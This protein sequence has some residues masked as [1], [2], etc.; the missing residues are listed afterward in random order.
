MAMGVTSTTTPSSCVFQSVPFR[1]ASCERHARKGCGGASDGSLFLSRLFTMPKK[2]IGKPRLVMDLSSLNK[3]LKPLCFKMLTVAQVHSVLREGD[4]LASLDLKDAYWHVPIHPRFRRFLAFQVGTETFQFTRLPFG[5]SI[6]PRV[7]TKLVRVVGASLAEAGISTLMYLDDWLIHSP[8]KEGVLNGVSVTLKVLGDMGFQVN[9]DKSAFTLEQKLCWL[10]IEWDT[11]N[12]SLSLAPDNALRTLRSVKRAYFS[13]TFSRRQWEGLLGCL[14]FAVPTL[15]LGRLKLRRLTWEVNS[16]SHPISRP[17]QTSYC[18]TSQPVASLAPV[19]GPSPVRSLV[20]TPT[21]VNSSDGRLRRRMGFPVQ[22][23]HQ[24]CGGWSEENRSLHINLWELLVVQEWLFRHHEIRGLSVR[25]DR[26]NVTAVHCIQRQGTARSRQLLALS[27][28]IFAEASLRQLSLS[29][30]FVPGQEN[31]WADALSRFRGSSVE[32]RLRPRVFDSL[33]LRYGTPQ[34]DLFDS[35]DTA[36]LP[37]YHTYNRRTRA[38]GPDAFT[39]D[40]NQW[41]FVYLFP[42]PATPVLLRVMQTFR[43]YKG[44]VLLITPYWPAQPCITSA[45]R[46]E[47]LRRALYHR[48][49][50]TA[51]DKML[52]AHRPSS[53]RQYESCWRRFQDYVRVHEVE[54]ISAST[55]LDFLAWLADSTNRAPATVSAHYAAL[56]DPLRFGMEIRVPRRALS[57]LLKYIRSS[58]A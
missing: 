45:S 6:A 34:V 4:W 25:F 23:G 26:D 38:G 37:L 40:W 2:D 43:S 20:P 50:S 54:V 9:W 36:Q 22:L 30:K 56:A 28:D 1:A 53:V 12:A 46:L 41:N 8:T 47:F 27:E 5:L 48:F 13:H 24:A 55:V 31:T 14:N 17:P 35:S 16:H 21:S 29:A 3:F 18:Y 11:I 57:L 58:R 7:F 33:T 32:W 10:G 44:R 51:V 52:R 19:W 39:E 49:S 42:P 15:L